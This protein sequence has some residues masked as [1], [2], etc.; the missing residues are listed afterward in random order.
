MKYLNMDPITWLTDGV[1]PA[2]RFHVKKEILQ[3]SDQEEN[4]N[5]LLKSDLT[6]Y[7]KRNFSNGTLGDFRYPDIFKKG[8][9]WF[10]LLA[11]ESGYK[12]NSDFVSSTADNL[13]KKIQ[14]KDGGFKFSCKSSD[15]AGCRSGDMIY[16]L[17]KS[18]V[19]DERTVKGVEWIIKNQRHDGGWLHCPVAGFGDA[20]KLIFFNKTGNGLK[21]ENDANVS[22]CPVASYS[23]LKAI[24]Q[25]N[26]NSCKDTIDKGI[27]FFIKNN[28]FINSKDKLFCGNNINYSKLG[29]P[30]MSQYDYLS[31]YVLV[32]NAKPLT[33]I[34]NVE[35]FNGIVKKQNPDGSWNCE[36]RFNG[37]I[38][39]KSEKSRWTTLNA[40]RMISIIGKE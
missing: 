21:Y 24:A 40:L 35:L 22:S 14:L 23:C 26:S 2:V 25:S 17:L 9:V 7:F 38:Y 6:D 34:V 31:G 29:Y 33:D 10:Y 30:V 19:S 3:L 16:A 32:L 39:E 37:M 12:N 1:N 20:M 28:F 18:G 36:N 13:C 15:A 27:N 8:T 5:E 4:Y 11:V